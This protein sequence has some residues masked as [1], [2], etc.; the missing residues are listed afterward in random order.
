MADNGKILP[1]GEQ[2]PDRCILKQC[3]SRKK[4][5]E[6][7]CA[8]HHDLFLSMVQ[9]IPNIMFPLPD[10]TVLRVVLAPQP[11]PPKESSIWTPEKPA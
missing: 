3:D 7:F 4:E 10:G 2:L 11:E 5:D 1:F 6:A 9:I 8:G